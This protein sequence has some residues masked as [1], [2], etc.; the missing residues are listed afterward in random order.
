[1]SRKRVNILGTWFD[2]VTRTEAVDRIV[3]YLKTCSKASVFTPNPE[4]VIEAYRDQEFQKVLNKSEMTIPDGIGVIIGAK[5]IGHPL[6]ERVAGYDTLLDVFA[7]I[8][9]EPYKVFFL[10]SGPGVADEAKDKILDR[11]PNLN[12][13]GTHDG[14]FRDDDTVIEYINSYEPDMLLVGLGAPKQEKWIAKYRDR[15]TATVLYG[16]GGSLDGFSGR[17]PR[18]PEIYIKL[19]LEWFHRLISQP[20]RAKRMLRLPLFLVKMMIEGRRYPQE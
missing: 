13:V 9:N 5:L 17:V 20:T 3:G 1:M 16:C 19:N 7:K 14:Y 2:H 15:L 11:Y 18:A 6:I 8:E 12:I 10:G 4:I